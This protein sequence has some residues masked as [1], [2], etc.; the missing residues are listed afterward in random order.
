MKADIL[1]VMWK[2]SRTLFRPGPHRS[3]LLGMIL[4]P[5][6]LSSVFPI[7]WGPDWVSE[8]PALVIAF[9]VPAVLVGVMIPDSFAGERER[10]TLGT[11]LAS[12]LPDRAILIGKMAI[13]VIAGWVTALVFTSLS[14]LVVNIAHSEGTWLCYT[15]SITM[16]IVGI[17][18]L[19]S[20]TM[21]CGGVL[22]S[23]RAESA[24]AATQNLMTM[25]IVPAMIAQVIPLLFM[26]K[27]SVVLDK[28]NGTQ[29]LGAFCGVLTV[30][31][32][33]LFVAILAR[34]RRSRMYL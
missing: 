25:I 20:T 18:L 31:D 14:L 11:L 17:S 33:V 24:Q 27:I 7:S 13:P 34:F 23:L 22:A 19:V 26:D 9:I 30:I 3:R 29:V 21:A 1:A 4:I 8:F 28:L 5:A 15:P 16:G 10:H 12:R 6:L 32:G 2:E